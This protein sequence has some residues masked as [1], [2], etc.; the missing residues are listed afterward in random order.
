LHVVHI[1]KDYA[2]VLGGIEGHIRTLAVG[3]VRRGVR[4]SVVVCQPRTEQLPTEEIMQ[5]VRVVRL[6]RDVD[7]ASAAFSWRHASIVRQLQPDLLH[8]QMPWPPGDLIS[9][10]LRNTPLIVSYQS[11][12]V[13]QRYAMRAYAPLLRYTLQRAKAIIAS[14]PA[15]AQ[16]SPWLKPWQSKVKIIPLGI[17]PP[18]PADN[19]LT[20]MWRTRLPFPFLLWVGRM[21]YYKGLHYAIEALAQLPNDIKLV[22]VGSGAV[23]RAL[24]AQVEQAG[25]TSR[26]VWLGDCSDADI[27]ALHALARIFI[28]PSHM[29]SE[30]FGLSLLEALAAGVPS[31]SCEI[32]TGTSFV[33]QHKR[34]GL[35]V[36]PANSHALAHAIQT[37]WYDE[38]MRQSM[39]QYARTWVAQNFH[40]EQMLDDIYDVYHDVNR[41]SE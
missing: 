14:S 21:R 22:L 30:A 24:I 8:L 26:V 27:A 23:Q 39:S 15:Y 40:A 3:L 25:L 7:I 34:T 12:V 37:L 5:G 13:R 36:P 9:A 19:A 1:Y 10:T 28:F 16:T 35:V 41:I 4:I 38:P 18:A 2:P 31:I 20:V 32:G 33:N 11:D 6:P 29:R 17:Q